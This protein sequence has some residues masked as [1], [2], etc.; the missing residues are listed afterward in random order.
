MLSSV[1]ASMRV[2]PDESGKLEKKL[3]LR[4]LAP[5]PLCPII[6]FHG[7]FSPLLVSCPVL[8]RKPKG[9]RE[10]YGRLHSDG[11]E[12]QVKPRTINDLTLP[13]LHDSTRLPA[14]ACQWRCRCAITREIPSLLFLPD[15]NNQCA[16]VG[17]R[18][19]FLGC[20]PAF[21]AKPTQ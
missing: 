21:V 16:S 8:R 17:Q 12:H 9:G 5:G 14:L 20:K 7:P 15:P 19:S 4:R 11:P 1:E 2:M 10:R 13:T 3:L 6:A 18:D